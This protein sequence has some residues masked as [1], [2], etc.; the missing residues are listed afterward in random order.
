MSTMANPQTHGA[1]EAVKTPYFQQARQNQ[2]KNVLYVV[3][4]HHC[5]TEAGKYKTL[6]FFHYAND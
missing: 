4:D 3:I 6:S 2:N 1:S 5:H